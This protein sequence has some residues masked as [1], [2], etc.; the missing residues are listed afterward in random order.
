M[1]ENLYLYNAGLYLLCCPTL[2]QLFSKD[3]HKIHFSVGREYVEF[4]LDCKPIASQ[5]LIPARQIDVNGEIVLGT[6]EPDGGTVPV[7]VRLTDIA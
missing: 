3:W 4:Y 5:P 7:S 2:F 1:F 6:R